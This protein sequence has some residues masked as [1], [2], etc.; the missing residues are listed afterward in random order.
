M[1]LWERT[2]TKSTRKAK[3]CSFEST[4]KHHVFGRMR[5]QETCQWMSLWRQFSIQ[6]HLVTHVY[7]KLGTQIPNKHLCVTVIAQTS[8]SELMAWLKLWSA[9]KCFQVSALLRNKDSS[10]FKR[11]ENESLWESSTENGTAVTQVSSLHQNDL[12]RKERNWKRSS[13]TDSSPLN[14]FWL[15]VMF[16]L[17]PR[18]LSTFL[19][20]TL[21]GTTFTPQRDCFKVIICIVFLRGCI[22]LS[23]QQEIKV[24]AGKRETIVSNWPGLKCEHLSWNGNPS[25][26]L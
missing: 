16:I 14:A 6:H 15:Q 12:R 26:S 20:V 24:T 4:R 3:N 2:K 13:K 17:L 22:H 1:V 19:I 5:R 25:L 11:N 18:D 21:L 7:M 23:L 9:V 8:D 10:Y